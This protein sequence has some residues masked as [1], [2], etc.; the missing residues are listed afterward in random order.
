MTPNRAKYHVCFGEETVSND[1]SN[2]S[3]DNERK[4]HVTFYLEQLLWYTA[5]FCST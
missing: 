1:A 5:N 2:D 3:D 4:Q